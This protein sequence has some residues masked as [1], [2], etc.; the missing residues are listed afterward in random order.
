M[1]TFLMQ[2]QFEIAIFCNFSLYFQVLKYFKMTGKGCSYNF[3]LFI[4][5][6]DCFMKTL[7][8]TQTSPCFYESAV[9]VY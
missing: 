5:L 1:R 7:T 9:Q 2:Q 8:L 4:S 3:G 6:D